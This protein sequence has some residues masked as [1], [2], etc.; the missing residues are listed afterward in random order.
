MAFVVF[1][2]RHTT[3]LWDG[4]SLHEAQRQVAHLRYNGE[5]SPAVG[6]SVY[7][8]DAVRRLLIGHMARQRRAGPLLRFAD[9]IPA[10]GLSQHLP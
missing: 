8:A 7:S 6:A 4:R 2:R 3:T 1:A 10:Q 5:S 9:A